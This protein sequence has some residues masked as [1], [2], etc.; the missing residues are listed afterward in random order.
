MRTAR[1]PSE[2]DVAHVNHCVE[3]ALCLD[4]GRKV[5]A[6]HERG[7]DSLPARHTN[8]F[9]FLGYFVYDLSP[10]LGLP[11]EIYKLAYNPDNC[12]IFVRMESI[13]IGHDYS[14]LS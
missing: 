9:Y 11:I 2:K 5:P 14:F 1:H 7:L 8:A 13:R 10:N 6:V 12:I 4:N 3:V